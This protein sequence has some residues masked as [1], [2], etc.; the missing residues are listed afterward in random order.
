MIV[1][2]TQSLILL[3]EQLPQNRFRYFIILRAWLH[4]RN[5]ESRH[6]GLRRFTR[7]KSDQVT[8]EFRDDWPMRMD[9]QIAVPDFCLQIW[10][11]QQDVVTLNGL[12]RI[13]HGSRSF[14]MNLKLFVD[15]IQYWVCE[16]NIKNSAI[17]VPGNGT[18]KLQFGEVRQVDLLISFSWPE[19]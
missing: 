1:R 4:V 18:V 8:S 3:G 10:H 12:S 9:K 14:S 13:S 6:K 7:I 19:Q 2:G 15:E 17:L 11:R 5:L 16:G